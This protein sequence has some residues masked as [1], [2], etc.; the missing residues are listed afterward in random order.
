MPSSKVFFFQDWTG[1]SKTG[2]MTSCQLTPLYFFII[3][4]KI[5]EGM[6]LAIFFPT[7]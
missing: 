2:T 7:Q 6:L 4:Q 5:G 1:T 3:I